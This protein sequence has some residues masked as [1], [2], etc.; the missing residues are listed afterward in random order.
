MLVCR[1]D[2]LADGLFNILPQN[3]EPLLGEFIKFLTR[4]GLT[5]IAAGANPR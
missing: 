2:F 5:R 1:Q 4:K 3:F